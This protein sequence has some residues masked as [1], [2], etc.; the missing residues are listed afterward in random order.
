MLRAFIVGLLMSSSIIACAQDDAPPAPQASAAPS[1]PPIAATSTPTDPN[2]TNLD[3]AAQT[4]QESTGSAATPDQ[5]DPDLA[6]LA[7]LPASDK[8]PAGKWQ[9]G[10][11]YQVLVPAQPT[12]VAAG[13]VQVDEVFWYG[14][15]HCYTLDPYLESW[16]KNKPEYI[17]F[18][19]VPVMWGPAH[20]SHARLFYTLQALN[21]M[22]LHTKVFDEIHQRDNMLVASDEARSKA[23]QLAFAKANGVA[24]ADFLREYDSFTVNSNLQRAEQLTRRYRVEGVP[25]VVIGGKYTTDVGSAGGQSKLVQLIDDLAASEK[26]R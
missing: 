10:K 6:R 23:M 9:A 21:R 16:K 7:A 20:K 1:A 19:R 11:H 22:D 24:E 18:A 3:A 4:Q 26:R 14:C 17:E 8:L 5:G 2:E 12:D 15:G 25:L 13:T